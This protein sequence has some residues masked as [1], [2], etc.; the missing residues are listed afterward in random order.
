MIK[1]KNIILEKAAILKALSA[2]A[3]LCLV[4]KLID[5]GEK[6]VTCFENCMDISQS[7]ISQHLAKL[8]DLNILNYRKEGNKVYY[9]CER[10]DVIKIVKTLFEDDF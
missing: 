8:K 7:S 2:P 4:K 10:E 1:D 5:E 9:Y 3:R 6:N